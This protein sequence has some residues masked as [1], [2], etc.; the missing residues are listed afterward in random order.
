M[1]HRQRT[2]T[3]AL[4]LLSPACSNPAAPEPEPGLPEIDRPVS[5]WQIH[6]WFGDWNA[7]WP[8]YHLAVDL[9]GDGGTPVVAVEDG[10]VRVALTGVEGY[11]AIVV[12]EHPAGGRT[13]SGTVLVLYGHLSAREGLAVSVG[14][15]VARGQRLGVLA[16]DDEDG[17]PWRPHLHFGVRDGPHHD[18]PDLCGVWL[19]VGYTRECPD[20]TH[21]EFMAN[22]W[23]DPVV[24]FGG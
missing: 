7:G 24:W 2:L 10:V 11:G 20:V 9:T 23:I 16:Y 8:G 4:A 22:G 19:Y 21:E 3:L 18:G 13:P 17:G 1:P 5:E 12:T 15:D 6:Q 14:Q